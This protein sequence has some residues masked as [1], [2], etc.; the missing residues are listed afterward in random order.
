MSTGEGKAPAGEED[1][2][3]ADAKSWQ[4]LNWE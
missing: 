2:K 1:E 4:G 3:A